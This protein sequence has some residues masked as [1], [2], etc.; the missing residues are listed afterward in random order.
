MLCSINIVTQVPT[1]EHLKTKWV[2]NTL[3]QSF[4]P[5]SSETDFSNVLYQPQTD[6]IVVNATEFIKGHV[7]MGYSEKGALY[8]LFKLDQNSDNII[9]LDETKLMFYKNDRNSK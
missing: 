8:A 6:F 2:A 5:S 3:N 1:F 4:A 7:M 9:D